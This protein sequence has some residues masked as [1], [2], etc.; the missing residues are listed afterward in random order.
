MEH[1]VQGAFPYCLITIREE[2]G[3]EYACEQL[4]ADRFRLRYRGTDGVEYGP[5][6]NQ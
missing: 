6:T 3:D 5:D 4:I 2:A 1:R